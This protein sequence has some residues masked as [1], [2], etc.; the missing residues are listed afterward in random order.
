MRAD[1][2]C[3]F[4]GKLQTDG[5]VQNMQYKV[6]A[7]AEDTEGFLS[8]GQYKY[9]S[10]GKYTAVF[11]IKTS[12]AAGRVESCINNQILC[13]YYSRELTLLI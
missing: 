7:G 4:T 13:V 2:F 3:G 1:Q 11:R 6:A 10:K 9:L 8:F 12:N 5:C